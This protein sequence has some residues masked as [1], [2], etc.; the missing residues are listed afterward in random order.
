M[1]CAPCCCCHAVLTAAMIY[2]VLLIRLHQHNAVVRRPMDK[3]CHCVCFCSPS[4]RA[5][6]TLCWTLALLSG[7]SAASTP[8]TLYKSNRCFERARS[9]FL[10]Y[11]H[12]QL[13]IVSLC[14][15]NAI[16]NP[17]HGGADTI[18]DA[19]HRQS[20]QL[21]HGCPALNEYQLA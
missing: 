8:V 17:W 13:W 6:A 12:E 1:S 3:Y 4:Y 2:L 9:L 19:L 21:L 10:S 20:K 16:C 14:L 18:C 11:E 7:A 15:I 5:H